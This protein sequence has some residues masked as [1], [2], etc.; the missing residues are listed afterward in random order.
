M[1]IGDLIKYKSR[2]ILVVGYAD[3]NGQTC[4]EKRFKDSDKFGWIVGCETDTTQ[5]R[6][7]KPQECEVISESR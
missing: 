3:H 7:Y 2:T 6:I 4:D 5:R 1:K